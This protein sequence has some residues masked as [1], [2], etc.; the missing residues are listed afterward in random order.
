ML[1]TKIMKQYM[2]MNVPL[3]A[4]YFYKNSHTKKC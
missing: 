1:Y 2:S 3:Y 4:V